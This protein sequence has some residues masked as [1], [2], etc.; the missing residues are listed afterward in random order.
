MKLYE[1][2]L[3]LSESPFKFLY[4]AKPIH[5][6]DK[7]TLMD[8]LNMEISRNKRN[9]PIAKKNIEK[10]KLKIKN[11]TENKSLKDELLRKEE[12]LK[13]Y[14]VNLR[15]DKNRLESISKK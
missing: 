2:Y 4:K 5:K 8:Y 1:Q 9:I 14:I 10:L 3:I 7:K 12:R 13:Y 6:I 15:K 11:N